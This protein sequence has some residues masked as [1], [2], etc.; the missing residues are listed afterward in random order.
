M[1]LLLAEAMANVNES[2]V[3]HLASQ[4]TLYAFLLSGQTYGTKRPNFLTNGTTI[5]WTLRI[6]CHDMLYDDTEYACYRLAHELETLPG[7]A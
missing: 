5:C 3:S 2:F 7:Y 6:C 1:I 4:G